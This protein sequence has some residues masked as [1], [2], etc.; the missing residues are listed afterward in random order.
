MMHRMRTTKLRESKLSRVTVLIT[1]LLVT[2]GSA[3]AKSRKVKQNEHEARIVAHISFSGLSAVDMAMHI[4]AN[5][6]Y[7]LYVQHSKDEG[8]SIVDVS[9]PAQSKSLGVIS[10]PD[11]AVSSKMV[12]TGDLAIISE[13]ETLPTPVRRSSDQLVLWDLSNPA[14]P[15]VVQTFTGVIKWLQDDRNFIYVLNGEGLWVVSEPADIR[16]EETGSTAYGG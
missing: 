7:Y 1:L 6:K 10:W 2:L 4:K 3:S 5:D 15:R 12:V 14:S 13:S 11:P 16:S 8:V 9:R